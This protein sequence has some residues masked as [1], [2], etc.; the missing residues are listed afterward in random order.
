MPRILKKL[1]LL[2]C[3]ISQSVTIECG[4]CRLGIYNLNEL[5]NIFHPNLKRFGFGRGEMGSLSTISSNN[6]EV[7]MLEEMEIDT[8]Q[9]CSFGAWSRFDQAPSKI[10]T[11]IEALTFFDKFKIRKNIKHYIIKWQSLE[12]REAT[13]GDKL[14][15]RFLFED[16]KLHPLLEKITFI[17]RD[18]AGLETLYI[19]I[20]K[21]K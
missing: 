11:L 18:G 14:L 19:E 13:E 21:R 9:N 5:K 4:L 1:F 15:T 20:F 7:G 17:V 8:R 12:Y 3:G 6:I 16:F 10:D 2:C